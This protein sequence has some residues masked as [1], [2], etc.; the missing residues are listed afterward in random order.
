VWVKPH[1]VVPALAVWA[2]SVAI[3][4]RREPRRRLAVDFV[5]LILGGL[6]AGVPGVA[7]LVGTGAWPYFLDIFLNWNPAYLAKSAPLAV[8]LHTLFTC[9][10][11]WSLIHFAA[12]PLALCSLWEARRSRRPGE[13]NVADEALFYSPA[14]TESAG[15]ARAILAAFYLGWFAQAV[16]VQKEFEYV[17]LP[18]TLIALAV[19]AGQRWCVGFAY[20]VWFAAV[21]VLVSVAHLPLRVE[22]H[23]LTQPGV[24]EL[25]PRCWREGS[26]PELR[27]RL[28]QYTQS[29]WGTNWEELTD[30]ARYLRGVEPPLGPGELNCWHDTTHPLYLMLNLDPA[31]RYMHYGT[32]FGIRPKR[33]VIAEEVRASRQRYVV[34]DLLRMTWDRDKV[35]D[36]AQWRA[37]DPLPAWLPP[38]E[39]A[40]FPWNQPVVFRSGRYLV[41]RIDRTRP[42]GVI[43]VTDWDKV[44][45]LGELGPDE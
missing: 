36:P 15:F 30:V 17:Y 8:R 2:A 39:R 33:E 37:G 45:R 44:D 3:L 23:R 31:T 21:G 38:A 5:G 19:V 28:G 24:L 6:L 26:S 22:P 34:S 25:W 27:D 10:G 11:A 12:I 40:K 16:F 29:P 20:L 1:A 13:A 18:L 42:L 4:S 14:A 43:R 9:F 35:Y 7:W 41:H 32:A